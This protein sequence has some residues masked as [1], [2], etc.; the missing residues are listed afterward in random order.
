MQVVPFL[1]KELQAKWVA[2]VLSGKVPLPSE[3]SMMVSIDEDY[4]L[5]IEKAGKPKH[6]SHL[7]HPYEVQE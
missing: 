7:L 6:H 5:R 1:V 3:D 2:R 4:Y